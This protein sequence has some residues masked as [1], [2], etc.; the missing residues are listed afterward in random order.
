MCGS[1]L[2]YGSKYPDQFKV[3]IRVSPFVK[4]TGS[5]I[6]AP[7]SGVDSTIHFAISPSEE[8]E[9]RPVLILMLPKCP[10]TENFVWPAN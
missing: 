5:A 2:K 10:S 4:P 1:F 8:I 7:V 6:F 3:G 9:V